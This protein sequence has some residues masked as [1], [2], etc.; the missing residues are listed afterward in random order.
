MLEIKSARKIFF[1][2]QADEKIA[3]D[4]LSLS[5][6]TGDFGVVIGSNGAG[7]SS[8]LNAISGALVLDSGRV[9][10]NETDVTGMPVHKRATK[11]ARVFQ[12]PMKGTAASMTVAENMLLADLRS[13]K[14]R[15]RQGLN[16]TRLAA[17]KERLSLLGLGLENRL[18]TRVELLSGGQRQSLSLIMAVGGE[19]EL[20]LLD[21]HTAAL[22]PRTA[23]IVM[24]A[25]IRAVEALKLTTLMVTHNMQ[26]AVDYGNRILMLDAGKVR[27]EIGGDEK[28]QTT[29]ADLIGH[30][31]VKS[32]RMLLA[33]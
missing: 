12:D 22:D 4:G 18:D 29:V 15:L 6:K 1:K 3:L 31:A 26:H 27:L 14:R 33:S 25:T 28:K 10:I 16:A 19:P 21:E 5:L 9:Q 11:L 24:K 32:D 30:F 7:K 2:G 8:M 20:L 13:Q 17:Y 23:D